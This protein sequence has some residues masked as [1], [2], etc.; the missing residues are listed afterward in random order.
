MKNNKSKTNE[1]DLL[2]AGLSR[3]KKNIDSYNFVDKIL[4]PIIGFICITVIIVH[5][6]LR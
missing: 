4:F 3:N 2:D 6:M 5:K 1:D